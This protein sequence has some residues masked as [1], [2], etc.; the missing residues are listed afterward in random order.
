MTRGEWGTDNFPGDKLS[1]GQT[2]NFP[3]DETYPVKTGLLSSV[4]CFHQG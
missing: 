2:K 3:G 4:V 1:W